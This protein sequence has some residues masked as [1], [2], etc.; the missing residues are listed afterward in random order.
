LVNAKLLSIALE[1]IRSELAR[2]GPSAED[3]E[4]HVQ[5][6]IWLG[7]SRGHA[8]ELVDSAA[9]Y[10]ARRHA[11]VP[12]KRRATRSVRPSMMTTESAR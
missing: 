1:W 11:I 4:I 9:A 3:R 6:L 7:A 2:S 12:E 5:M 10:G 8:V